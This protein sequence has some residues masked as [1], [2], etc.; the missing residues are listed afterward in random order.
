MKARLI[1]AFD[2]GKVE[3]ALRKVPLSEWKAITKKKVAERLSGG[4]DAAG[5]KFE[6]FS[7][8]LNTHIDAGLAA[9]KAMPDLTIEDSKAR[10]A[11]WIDH[12][13][14]FKRS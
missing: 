1:A 14:K 5:D 9:I 8:E 6:K 10:A 2:S 13:S 3:A 12:M 4:V 7:G 11:A